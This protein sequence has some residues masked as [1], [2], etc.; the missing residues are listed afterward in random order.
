MTSPRPANGVSDW[1]SGFANFPYDPN[2]GLR[3]NFDQLAT[4]R[5]W[6]KKLKGKRWAECQTACF[7]ALYGGDADQGNLEKWQDLC[8]EVH[9]LSPPGCIKDCKQVRSPWLSQT[10]TLMLTFCLGAREP[11]GS[12]QSC[13]S[14][15]SPLYWCASHPL[16]NLWR[17]L[18]L[19]E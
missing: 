12:G 10:F 4:Q 6:G 15:R 1:F 13:E 7:S 17:L 14:Y 8:R 18:R 2:S 9:I 3:S 11:Q 5:K 16:Q 19:H